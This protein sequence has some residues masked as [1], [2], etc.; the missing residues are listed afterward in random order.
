MR[1]EREGGCAHIWFFVVVSL[2]VDLTNIPL[3]IVVLTLDLFQHNSLT[4]L[5]QP[6]YG[7]ES[8]CDLLTIVQMYIIVPNYILIALKVFFYNILGQ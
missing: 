3:I 8:V 6:L 7:Y 2:L 1:L 5:N 4:C